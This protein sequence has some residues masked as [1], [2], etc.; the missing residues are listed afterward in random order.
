MA[1]ML[2]SLL[3]VRNWYWAEDEF[4]PAMDDGD[5]STADGCIKTLTGQIASA[6][7][8]HRNG[9]IHLI[10]DRLGSNKQF[11][12]VHESGEVTVANYLI[13]LVAHGAPMEGI[14]SV[15]AG[16]VLDIDVQAKQLTLRRYFDVKLSNSDGDG[17]LEE[18]AARIRGDLERWFARLARQFHSRRICVCTSGGLDSGLIGALAVQYFERVTFYTYGYIQGEGQ[19]TDDAAYGRRLADF[20]QCPF[21]YVPATA[22]DILS[23]VERAL[24]YGQDWRDFNVHCAIV[25]DLLGKAIRQD[26]LESKEEAPPLVLTGDLMNEFL[27]DY[28]VVHYRGHEYY[29]LPR[30]DPHSLRSVLIKGLDAGDREVGVFAQHGIDLIQPYGLLADRYLELP[31][32]L[33]CGEGAKQRLVKAIAGDLLPAWIFERSKVRAQIGSAKEPVGILPLL[34]EA[35]YDAKWL[36]QAFCRLFGIEDVSFLNGFIWRGRY[37]FATEFPRGGA[38]NGYFT[39]SHR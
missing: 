36:Q 26:W 16:H 24:L 25:N 39:R 1:P 9:R 5:G 32:A 31:A 11:F 14:F 30:L 4:C 28:T 19:L 3:R 15:P 29:R 33:V 21:R 35:G 37:R 12:A 20:L 18:Y 17:G 6:A 22:E 10:R 13:D 8:D 2:N 27:A 38:R 34:H 23:A 7:V